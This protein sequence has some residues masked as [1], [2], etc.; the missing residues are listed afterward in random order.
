[1]PSIETSTWLALKAR[2]D[3]LVLSPALAI[4][5]PK[6]DFTP[7]QSSPPNPK[8]LPYLEVRHLPNSNT[9]LGVGDTDTHRRAGILQITLKYPTVLNHAEAAQAEIAGQIAAHFPAGLS[10]THGA[11][12]LRVEKAPDVLSAFREGRDPYWKTPVSI[13]YFAFA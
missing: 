3:T 4:A 12:T 7:P 6:E 10:M 5:W 9:R 8:P 2:V 13:R 11:L 1:M